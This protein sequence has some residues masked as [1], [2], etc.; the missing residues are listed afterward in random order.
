MTTREYKL[1]VGST[2]DGDY[3]ARVDTDTHYSRAVADD[4][5]TAALNAVHEAQFLIADDEGGIVTKKQSALTSRQL[6]GLEA[7]APGSDTLEG[8]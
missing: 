7:Y 6:A 4:P 8:S 1:T 2:S 3:W 5:W